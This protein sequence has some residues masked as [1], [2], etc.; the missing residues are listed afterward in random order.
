MAAAARRPGSRGPAGSPVR[1]EQAGRRPGAGG[2][3]CGNGRQRQR[4]IPPPGRRGRRAARRG[5]R[6]SGPL[7]PRG[8][9]GAGGGT[10]GRRQRRRD[11]AGPA[12]APAARPATAPPAAAALQ[13]ARSRTASIWP[14]EIARPTPI[15]GSPSITTDPQLQPRGARHRS[16]VDARERETLVD[17][18]IPALEAASSFHKY[19]DAAAEPAL[20]FELREDRAGRQ[21]HAH[22][23][24]LVEHAGFADQNI[25]IEIPKTRAART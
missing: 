9:G 24:R 10:G 18:H 8:A 2:R 15:P 21:R 7:R 1:P 4:G 6:H 11:A 22:R 12:G 25:Q 13:A 19:K 5:R 17:S 16:R 14:N 3:R 23:L 20:A